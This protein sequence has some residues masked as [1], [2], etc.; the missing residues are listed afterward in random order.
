MPI[1]RRTLAVLAACLSTLAPTAP[2]HAA[3][4]PRAATPQHAAATTPAEVIAV[5][6]QDTPAQL[7]EKA[8]NVVPS[9]RQKAWQQRPL[10]SFVHFGP[11]TFDGREWGTGTEDPNIVNPT[12]LDTDQWASTLVNAGFQQVIFTAKHHDGF[13]MYPS[14]Y[15]DFSIRSSSWRNGQ[16]DVV[17]AFTDSAH[18]YG[19]KVGFYLSPADLHEAL[20]GG[21]YDNG[22]AARAVTIPEAAPDGTR[23]SGPATFDVVA[24]DYNRYYMNTLY[25]LLTQY[26]QVDEVWFDGANPTGRTQQYQFADWS[27]IVRTLQPDAVMFG[28][29]DLRWVGN[30]NG[31]ART[32]EFSALPF[33]GTGSA[34][35]PSNPADPSAADLGSDAVL[36]RQGAW[37]YLKWSPAECDARLEKD[38]FW[39]P[40]NAPKTL[41]QLQDMYYTSVGR[42]CV[43]LLD[44]PPDNTG[45]LPAADVARLAEFAAWRT[46]QF[47]TDLARGGAATSADGGQ[48]GNAVDGNYDTGWHPA[49]A[50]GALTV[51]LGAARSV[52][53]LGVQENIAA[54]QRVTAFAVDT[55]N[56][57]AWTQAATGTAIGYQRL[58]KLSAP[59]VTSRLRLRITGARGAPTISTLSG[60]G[61][62][63]DPANL[64]LGRPASQSST[65]AGGEA[66]RAV[67]GN[68]DGGYFT[69]SVTHTAETVPEPYPW[70]QVDLGSS[71]PIGTVNVFNRTDCCANRLA[72]Y[73][74][75]V[76]DTPFDTAKSPAQQA[77]TAGVWSAHQTTQAAGPTTVTVGRPGRYA[78]V[79][80]STA[81]ILS[82]AEVEVRSTLAGTYTATNAGSGRA[83]D[84]PGGSATGTQLVQWT[85]N[86]GAH[87][88]W[89]LTAGA[90]GTYTI[91][92][93]ASGLCVDVSGGSTAAGAAVIQWT[94]HGGTNQKW[95]LAR[96]GAGYRI[97]A[98]N[99]GLVLSVASTAEG[100]PVTQQPDTGAALQ[101]W[102]LATA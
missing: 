31:V 88:K 76:S 89:R 64:A 100:A 80:Q 5:T 90:D 4:V 71:Q 74:L 14:R 6:P 77:A 96:V 17:R 65:K 43:L 58:V 48:P 7:L 16:G 99:S 60:Y 69:G 25:E 66:A 41:A 45:R 29:T 8:A 44:T 19:I 86:G 34:D 55:W 37:N 49:T 21:R 18:R 83:L 3:P 15:S 101:L 51:D 67:D 92:N 79:Q 62:A 102:N 2:A 39:H 53:V 59:V 33:T 63:G 30:E 38:W 57:T 10:T 70:W 24:D 42:N 93:V 94:C 91:V 84:N 54:G 9:P 11:N 52:S 47:G 35:L 28:G 82:L 20:A 72:D 87:Q 27:R 75:F 46:A 23:P 68:T 78:L 12:A 32:G 97:T 50:T 56:G 22:S 73:W 85:P 40:G 26:G 81:T 98:R 61:P 1:A 36:G 13:L 95:V